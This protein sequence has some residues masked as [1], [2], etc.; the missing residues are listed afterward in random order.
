MRRLWAK[1][2]KDVVHILA[3]NFDGTYTR[4]EVR[5]TS[6]EVHINTGNYRVDHRKVSHLTFTPVTSYPSPSAAATDAADW[7]IG[8]S[9]PDGPKFFGMKRS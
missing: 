4:A 3:L 2:H 8:T 1:V 7:L 9:Q 6:S 5:L